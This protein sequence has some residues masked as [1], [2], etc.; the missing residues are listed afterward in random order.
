MA[1]KVLTDSRIKGIKPKEHAY[2]IWQISG[3]RGTGRLGLKIYPSGRKVFVYKYHKAGARKF[4]SLGDY[5]TI[6]LAEATAKSLD[7]LANISSPEKI[8]LCMR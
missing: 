8:R 6:S 1:G 2:Y 3:T 7:A 4:L 5:P